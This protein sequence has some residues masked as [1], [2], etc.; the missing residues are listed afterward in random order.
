M[1]TFFSGCNLD[2]H[3]GNKIAIKFLNNGSRCILKRNILIQTV[4]LRTGNEQCSREHFLFPGDQNAFSQQVFV[5]QF[6]RSP[7]KNGGSQFF[8]GLWRAF[9]TFAQWFFTVTGH[10]KMTIVCMQMHL[11]EQRPAVTNHGDAKCI[12]FKFLPI[13]ISSARAVCPSEMLDTVRKNSL[14]PINFSEEDISSSSLL[15]P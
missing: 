1:L 9:G 7:V 11:N 13:T 2:S 12:I 5:T 14:A 10:M 6:W 4:P 8:L 15:S 3:Y